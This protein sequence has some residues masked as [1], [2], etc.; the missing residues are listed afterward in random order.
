M[1]DFFYNFAVAFSNKIVKVNCHSRLIDRRL[2]LPL[3]SSVLPPL[4]GAASSLSNE[5]R[6]IN[7]IN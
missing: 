7:P 6:I 3:S 4:R 1:S 5:K 2:V